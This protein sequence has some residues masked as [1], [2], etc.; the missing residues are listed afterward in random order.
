MW[1]KLDYPEKNSS[2]NLHFQRKDKV[3]K[4]RSEKYAKNLLGGNAD[5]GHKLQPHPVYHSKR[6]RALKI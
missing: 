2:Y 4:Q 3:R 6:R 1:I 5:G